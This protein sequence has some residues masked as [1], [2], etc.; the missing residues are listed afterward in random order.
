MK[1]RPRRR[2][3]ILVAALVCLLVSVSLVS[4]MIAGTLHRR[5]QL[6][7]ERQARQAVHLLV[8][9]HQRA[10]YQI[11]Q[12]ND[13]RGETWQMAVSKDTR[14]EVRIKAVPAKNDL[15]RVEVT[16]L[17]PTEDPRAVRRSKTFYLPAPNSTEEKSP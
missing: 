12:D 13:Y 2:A 3:A 8:A 4:T 7:V 14:G 6:K 10:G 16:A 15:I 5:S 11:R 17:Y 9:G 1:R